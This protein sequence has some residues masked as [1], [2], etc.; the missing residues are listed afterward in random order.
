MFVTREVGENS[1][2]RDLELGAVLIAFTSGMAGIQ[3]QDVVDSL[4]RPH[5][6]RCGK[7][8]HCHR[9]HPQ[10]CSTGGMAKASSSLPTLAN[11]GLVGMSQWLAVA[12][13]SA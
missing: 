13:G 12:I 5:R 1:D 8:F 3:I 4:E 2:C 6:L 7:A 10:F 9:T 11:N